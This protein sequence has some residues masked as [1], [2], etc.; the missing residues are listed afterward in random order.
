MNLTQND[1]VVCELIYASGLAVTLAS[2]AS[3]AYKSSL[4]TP[5]RP[6]RALQSLP[7]IHRRWMK[8]FKVRKCLNTETS[9][10]I[11]A[12][13]AASAGPKK[14]SSPPTSTHTTRYSLLFLNFITCAAKLNFLNSGYVFI[15]FKF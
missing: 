14:P 7:V 8:L 10:A 11:F 9:D 6:H 15:F 12:N 13:T 2:L 3:A 1:V 5:S 4:L